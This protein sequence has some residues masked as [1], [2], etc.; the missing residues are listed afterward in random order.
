METLACIKSRRSIRKFLVKEVPDEIIEKIIEA[1]KYAPSS[2][3]SQPWQF[4]VIRSQD[5]KSELA[6]LDHED[7][8]PIIKNS[9]AVIL[10]CVDLDKSPVR[11]VEDGVLAAQNI[12]LAINALGLGSVYLSAYKSDDDTKEK[13][14]RSTLN[15][16]NNLKP[17][18]LL[19]LGYQEESEKLEPKI[20]RD[21]KN[22][23]EY[24]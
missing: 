13:G 21:N 11:S 6:E 12:L 4:F 3:D 10:V 7:N 14:I 9:S 22:L 2:H 16:S 15:L 1:G 5:L 19:P 18:A 8:R 17:I 23:I 24:R 20:V